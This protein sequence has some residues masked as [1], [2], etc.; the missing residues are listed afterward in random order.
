MAT[1]YLGFHDESKLNMRGNWG[2]NPQKYVE[3][4][5]ESRQNSRL[6]WS[7]ICIEHVDGLELLS[8]SL[9]LKL[10]LPPR[11]PRC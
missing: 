5:M 9:E 10:K 3:E 4:G 6:Q 1:F 8:G 7:L 2:T 11:C